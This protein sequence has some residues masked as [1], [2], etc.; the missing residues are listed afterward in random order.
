MSRSGSS[1][2]S[3]I[4]EP[5]TPDNRDM[6]GRISSMSSVT[7]EGE[8]PNLNPSLGGERT[9][10]E[11]LADIAREFGVEAQLVQA[12]AQRLAGLC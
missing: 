5:K 6:Y 11:A 1:V 10:S 8:A 7:V 2:R 3:A 12:L 4:S 9:G